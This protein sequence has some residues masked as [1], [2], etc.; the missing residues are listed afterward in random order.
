MKTIQD[1]DLIDHP[2]VFNTESD[3]KI[4]WPIESG[5]DYDEN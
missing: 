2:S 3:T 1:N 4:L 5:V